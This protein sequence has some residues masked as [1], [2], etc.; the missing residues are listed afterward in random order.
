[1]NT[2]AKGL[3]AI[4]ILMALV[5]SAYT[6]NFTMDYSA[7][8][9]A[10]ADFDSYADLDLKNI[11]YVN[12]SNGKNIY[13]FFVNIT[14]V[15]PSKTEVDIYEVDLAG[16]LMNETTHNFYRIGKP[17]TCFCEFTPMKIPANSKVVKTFY[18]IIDDIDDFRWNG[19]QTP[20]GI[21]VIQPYMEI[22]YSVMDGGFTS[23]FA[24]GIPHSPCSSCEGRGPFD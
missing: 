3:A 20:T 7:S 18:L 13:Y 14:F 16:F 10:L 19:E 23:M 15:N 5:S 8:M 17:T 21:P 11:H 22:R 1:M 12:G 24:Y 4:L 6:V 9:A 2:L